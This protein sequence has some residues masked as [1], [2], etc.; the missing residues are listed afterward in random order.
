MPYRCQLNAADGEEAEIEIVWTVHDDHS[1]NTRL[2]QQ[3]I[4]D[5]LAADPAA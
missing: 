1:Y 5:I 3:N 2:M 4:N